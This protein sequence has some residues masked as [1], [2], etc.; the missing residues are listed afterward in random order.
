MALD[1]RAD[2][3]PERRLECAGLGRLARGVVPGG[4]GVVSGV[5]VAEAEED[6]RACPARPRVL[7]GLHVGPAECCWVRGAERELV[8]WPELELL[9][10]VGL[11][12]RVVIGG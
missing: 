12:H 7:E 4:E 6:A 11:R 1:L 3:A 10:E 2:V 5:N 9:H 8:S